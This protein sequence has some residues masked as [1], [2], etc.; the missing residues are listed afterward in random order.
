[1]TDQS[2]ADMYLADFN[3]GDLKVQLDQFPMIIDWNDVS[4]GKLIEIF[5]DPGKNRCQRLLILKVLN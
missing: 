3:W 2:L 4:F 5:S 1:M